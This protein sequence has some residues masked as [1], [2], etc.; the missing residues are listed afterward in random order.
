MGP[1]LI[2]ERLLRSQ[3][4]LQGISAKVLAQQLK[5][6]TSTIYRRIKGKTAF[7]VPEIQT[8]VKTLSLDT[9]MACKIFFCSDFVLKD[10][11]NEP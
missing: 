1:P 8:C 5:T 6:S 7:T 9:D 11:T 3:M 2:N 10:K 4:A